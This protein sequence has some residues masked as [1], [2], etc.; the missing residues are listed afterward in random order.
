MAVAA[1]SPAARGAAGDNV[2]LS[3]TVNGELHVKHADTIVAQLA[4]GTA[5]IGKLAANNGID[6]GDVDVTSVTPGTTS[7]SL[8]KAR[9]VAAGVNDTG[10]AVLAVRNDT[11][12]SLAEADGDYALLRVNSQG[13]LYVTGASGTTQYAEDAAHNTGDSGV[14][15]LAVR[16]DTAAVGSGTDGDYSTLNVTA[17]GN[18][19]VCVA[20]EEARATNFAAISAASAGDNT[21]KTAVVGKK[22]R[23]TSGL[24]IAA[25][26]VDV[27]FESGAG[28][29]ALSGV[30]SLAAN[31]GFVLP[32]NPVGW[33]ETA[34]NT[35]LNL[36]L[37]AAVQV[38]GHFTYEEV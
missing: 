6:I 23:V 4:A 1:A 31:A 25:A 2:A 13:A 10:V 20:E 33:F 38:S 8:G 26:A 30:M 36:E 24:L 15:M 14:M 9:S 21:L 3:A 37:G 17:S 16:R 19:R 11:P 34:A 12:A 29:T 35:L 7:A 27:R 22:I 32:Y 5:S 28:G 18:L